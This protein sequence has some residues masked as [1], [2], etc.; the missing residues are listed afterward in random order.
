MAKYFYKASTKFG[1]IKEGEIDA[2]SAEEAK[3]KLSSTGLIPISVSDSENVSVDSVR[4]LDLSAFFKKRKKV[5]SS[6]ILLFTE[7]LAVLLKSGLPIDKSLA[8]MV[9]LSESESM[10]SIAN[11]LL[12]DVNSGKSLADAMSKF[13]D[14]FSKLYVNMIKAGESAGVVDTVMEQLLDYLR[15]KEELKSYVISSLIY[16]ALLLVVG[17]LTVGILVGYVLPKFQEIFESMGQELPVPTQVMMGISDFLIKY[18]WFIFG[19][20]FLIWFL[21]KRWVSTEEGRRKRDEILLKL[22]VIKRLVVESETARLASTA[23]ILITS[24]VPLIQTLN[25]VKEIISNSLIKDAFE[26]VIKG[27]KK[28]EGV[29][30]PMM[31][32][33]IF[34]P[35]AVHL[36]KVGEESGTLGKMF[37]KVGEIFQENI[38]K[39]IKAFV[40]L[41]E[42]IL[43]LVMG[44]IVGLIVASMLMAIFSINEAP[45]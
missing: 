34:P 17:I 9:E 27:A 24:A 13:P 19:F 26:P 1:E 5:K 42:P 3:K 23:G 43:I 2:S 15:Q 11:S 31:Q 4:N 37:L 40:S 8:L 39:S 20:V 32:S 18:K 33:G 12:K 29:A 35:L 36:I 30:K 28:G 14:F 38:K 21:Y 10:K 41:F 44:I 6:D 25:I 45:F 7:K 16:P 22:P